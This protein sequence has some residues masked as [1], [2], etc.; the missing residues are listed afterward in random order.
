MK[1]KIKRES[2]KECFRLQSAGRYVSKTVGEDLTINRDEEG[3]W[4][5]SAKRD[6]Q[7]TPHA[8]KTAY[9][10]FCDFQNHLD[11]T[12]DNEPKY[13]IRASTLKQMWVVPDPE[14][15]TSDELEIEIQ[16]MKAKGYTLCTEQ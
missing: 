6:G 16:K 7:Y 10:A 3:M 12:V 9:E 8:F 11:N 2:M 1:D 5:V 15:L 14:G 13:I 4:T